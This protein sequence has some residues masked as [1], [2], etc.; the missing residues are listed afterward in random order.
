MPVRG[1]TDV[2]PPGAAPA[3][4][5]AVA[6]LDALAASEDGTMTLSD[7]SRALGVPKSST[8]TICTALELGG[9]VRRDDLGFSLGRKLVELGGAYLARLDQVGEFHRACLESPV[10]RDETL[11]LSTAAG[12]DVLCLAR[13]EGRPAIR[14]TT[15]IG[16]RL[17]SS[18]CAQ[19]KALLARLDDSEIE[20]LYHGIDELPRL[21]G[22]SRRTLPRLLKDIRLARARGYALDDEESADSVVGLAVVVPTRGVRAPILAISVTKH[23]SDWNDEVR[24]ELVAELKR[25][26]TLLGNP[27]ATG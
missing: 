16:D 7:L 27:M 20:R 10:L 15:N 3:V 14:L 13:Y 11:R 18:S 4:S 23:K 24:D 12:I 9:L 5:R 25:M 8:S 26:A 19:G 6:V 1:G 2:T 17:P 21:T 22:R